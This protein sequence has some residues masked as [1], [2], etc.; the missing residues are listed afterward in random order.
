M[1]CHGRALFILFNFH[2]QI[3]IF[4]EVI[5]VNKPSTFKNKKYRV[6]LYNATSINEWV[7]K[8]K[9]P[10]LPETLKL[11]K[12]LLGLGIKIAFLT[13]RSEDHRNVTAANLK[14]AGYHIW[15]KLILKLAHFPIYI[16]IYIHFPSS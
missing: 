8:G 15:E 11:Y 2:S 1:A 16:Y 6:E 10:A 9:A 13:G 3:L 14:N 4:I 5:Y 12:K 7:V